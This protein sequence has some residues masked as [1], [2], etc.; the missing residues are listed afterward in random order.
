MVAVERFLES[1]QAATTRGGYAQ[2]LNRLTTVA[3]P[4]HGWIAA[5]P[6]AAATAPSRRLPGQAVQ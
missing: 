3:G 1:L 4:Q 6:R 2:P 5:R